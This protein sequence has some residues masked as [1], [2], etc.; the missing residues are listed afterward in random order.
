MLLFCSILSLFFLRILR[1]FPIAFFTQI[2][3]LSNYYV[4]LLHTVIYST[5][6]EGF[7]HRST[8]K[9]LGTKLVPMTLQITPY[10][11]PRKALG[12]LDGNKVKIIQAVMLGNRLEENFD[13]EL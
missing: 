11:N 2:S 6:I 12:V 7:K 9:M 1:Y 10:L 3:Y 13:C 8:I 4:V 5:G